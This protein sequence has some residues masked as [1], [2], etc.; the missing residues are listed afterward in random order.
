MAKKTTDLK[1]YEAVGRRKE[2]VARVRLY[3]VTN[4]E[5][6]VNVGNHEIK[7]GEIFIN[8]KPATA[9]YCTKDE[10]ERLLLPLKLTQQEN[11]FAISVLTRGGGR[12]GQ[13]GAIVHGLSRGLILADPQLKPILRQYHLLTRDPRMK[14]RRKVGTGGKARRKKQSPK[15]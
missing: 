2:A 12:E 9:I 4:K 1:Y 6:K 14:E 15:R 3:L 13:L 5:G 8:G 10:M 7:K 11:R